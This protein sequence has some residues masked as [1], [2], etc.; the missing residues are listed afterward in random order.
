MLVYTY[1]ISYNKGLTWTSCYI[2]TIHNVLVKHAK[3]EEF[4]SLYAKIHAGQKLPLGDALVTS[5]RHKR[6]E[7]HTPP[8]GAKP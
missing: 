1:Y 8:Q 6:D 4:F 3:P 7:N 5:V 2:L